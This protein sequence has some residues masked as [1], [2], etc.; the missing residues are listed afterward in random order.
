MTRTNSSMKKLAVRKQDNLISV[1]EFLDMAQDHEETGGAFVARLKGQ[2]AIC[3][4]R[5][6]CSS[7]SCEQVT[8][9][10]DQMVCH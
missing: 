6:K 8:N 4:F 7:D 10:T 9:Y 3:D 1:V 5:S 2:A